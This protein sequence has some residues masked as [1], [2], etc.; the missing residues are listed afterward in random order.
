[1][2]IMG[3]GKTLLTA[4]KMRLGEVLVVEGMV[5]GVIPVVSWADGV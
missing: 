3:D 2:L 4:Y 5:G 1:M